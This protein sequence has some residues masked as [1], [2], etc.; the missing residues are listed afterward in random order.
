MKMNWPVVP[1][2]RAAEPGEVALD[3]GDGEGDPVDD[4]VVA[5]AAQRLGERAGVHVVGDHRARLGAA[6]ASA[7]CRG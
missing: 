5:G 3:V 7:T 1:P 6:G 4:D 2:R